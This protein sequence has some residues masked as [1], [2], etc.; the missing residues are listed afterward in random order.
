M[1]KK[2]KKK[3]ASAILS[4]AVMA[5]ALSAPFAFENQPSVLSVP[6]TVTANAADSAITIADMPSEYQYAADW[7]YQNRVQNEDSM[8]TKSKRWNSLFDQI[9][10]NNGE[11]NYVVRWQSTQTITYEQRKQF[12]TLVETGINQWASWL[13]G[14]ENWPFDHI[15]VNIV[16]WAVLDR[17]SL[18][19]IHDDEVIWDNIKEHD[20][21]SDSQAGVP[22]D[23]PCAP[24]ELWTFNYFYDRDH[25]YNGQSFDEY[26]WCTQNYGDYGGCGGDWGQRLSD[27]YYLAAASGSGYPH[28]YWHELGHGFGMTD[29]YGGEGESNGFPPGGF[30]GGENSIMMAGSASKITDFDGWFL[31]YLWTKIKDEEGRFDLSSV[32]PVTT[33]TTTTTTTAPIETTVTTTTTTVPDDDVKYG[34]KTV[35]VTDAESIDY[36]VIGNPWAGINGVVGHW[37]QTADDAG[38]NGWITEPW[39]GTLDENGKLTL[40]YDIPE[41]VSEVKIDIYWSGVWNNDTQSID[42]VSADVGDVIVNKKAIETTSTTTS[43]TTTTTTTKPAETTTTTTSEIPTTSTT[44][45]VDDLLYGDAN[46]DGKVDISDAVMILQAIANKDKYG[47]TGN[48]P[49]HITESGWRNADCSSVGDGVTTKDALAVQKYIIDLITLP[50]Q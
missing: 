3:L 37:D 31:R 49:T 20:D 19:D 32:T 23:L 18:L 39:E 15:K 2:S 12:E 25:V 16:G 24:A 30:P 40:H 9:I 38:E 8:G 46:T 17:N 7:I 14:Y 47:L 4:A 1:L 50:E 48:D 21:L 29:F 33:T 44:T 43:E 34:S 42:K 27:N 5:S 35:D 36:T 11:L 13:S 6:A 26:L 22:S 45:I 41:G 28:I 10:A